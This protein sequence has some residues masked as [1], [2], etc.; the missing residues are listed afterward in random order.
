MTD[1]AESGSTKLK[2]TVSGF[3]PQAIDVY[4]VKGDNDKIETATSTGV[5][6]NNDGTYYIE[7]WIETDPQDKY[8]HSCHIE[9]ESLKST[10]IV[11]LDQT[12]NIALIVG[13]VIAVVAVILIVVI[14]VVIW[15]KKQKGKDEKRLME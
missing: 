8:H 2:C 9:H 13:I 4:F 12:S 10:L 5:L 1:I 15:K 11:K 14:A 6:P 7:K 3:H